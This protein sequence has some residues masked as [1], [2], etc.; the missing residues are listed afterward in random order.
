MKIKLNWVDGALLLCGALC[1]TAMLVLKYTVAT[2]MPLWAVSVPFLLFTLPYL[3][4]VVMALGSIA[5]TIAVAV[6]ILLINIL[7]TIC[8]AIYLTTAYATNLIKRFL[9]GK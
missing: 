9:G 1:S 2:T 5:I 7:A 6:F 4:L 8:L 3:L